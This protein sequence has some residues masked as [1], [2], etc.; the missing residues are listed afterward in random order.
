MHRLE[1]VRSIGE[2]PLQ[3][4]PGRLTVDLAD[5][6]AIGASDVPLGADEARAVCDGE[7]A[8]GAV[9]HERCDAAA[10]DSIVV[11]LTGLLEGERIACRSA[12]ECRSRQLGF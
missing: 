6:A 12:D 5:E 8:I 11:K 3:E 9:D 7:L 1:R 4:V 10:F 2:I